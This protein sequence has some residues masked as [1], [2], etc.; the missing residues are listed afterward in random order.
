MEI[1]KLIEEFKTQGLEPEQIIEALEKMCEEG[2]LS[3][4]DLEKAKQLLVVDPVEVEKKEKEQAGQL[5]GLD[6]K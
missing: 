5:F 1:E 2:K 3:P 6:L 4:E